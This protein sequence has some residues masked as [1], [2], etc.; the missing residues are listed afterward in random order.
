[1]HGAIERRRIQVGV[2][3]K[4]NRTLRPAVQG[5]IYLSDFFI[6]NDPGAQAEIPR[7]GCHLPAF[8]G[9]GRTAEQDH[10]SFWGKSEIESGLLGKLFVEP[11][12][13]QVQIAQQR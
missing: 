13:A 11:L 5:G 1:M 12:A 6:G 10:Q 7:G 2:I 4:I 8:M 9:P 3:L